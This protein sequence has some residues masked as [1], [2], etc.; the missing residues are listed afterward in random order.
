MPQ[1]IALL[2]GLVKTVLF[3]NILLHVLKVICNFPIVLIKVNSGK[4]SHVSELVTTTKWFIKATTYNFI[5][6]DTQLQRC[7]P[8]NLAKHFRTAFCRKYL[9][10]CF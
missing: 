7:F 3:A 10:H 4:L 1:L 6:K 2:P 9:D 8:V 5:R